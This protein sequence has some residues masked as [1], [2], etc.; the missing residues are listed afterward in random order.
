MNRY[1]NCLGG[2]KNKVKRQEQLVQRHDGVTEFHVHQISVFQ[3]CLVL[4][5][6]VEEKTVSISLCIPTFFL[7]LVWRK[8][9]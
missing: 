9:K 6:C 8:W 4:T 2:G 3:I 1:F 5:V 7:W